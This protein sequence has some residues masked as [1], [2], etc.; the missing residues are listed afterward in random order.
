MR[1]SCLLLG[2]RVLKRC[3]PVLAVLTVTALF[4]GQTKASSQPYLPDHG[5]NFAIGNKYV[6]ET[7]LV[8]QGPTALFDFQR[9]YNSTSTE[10]G[11]LGYGW[12]CSLT[13]RLKIDGSTIT[14]VL[15]TGRHIA[16]E[17]DGAGGW[18]NQLGETSR[19]VG[20][21]GGY[22]LQKAN[23]SLHTYD[24]QGRL[25][26]VRQRN[27]H[28]QE[29]HYSGM[30]LTAITD[31]FGKSL[32]FAYNADGKLHTLT[33]PTG[34]FT[35]SY[36]DD[37][38]VAVVRPDGTTRHYRYT[39]AND[40]HNLTTIDD[41]A[42]IRITS[43]GYDSQDRVIS[44]SLAG[45][46]HVTI[47]YPSELSRTVT[48]DGGNLTTYQLEI[49]NGVARVASSSG[50]GCSSCGSSGADSSY[51]Y[52]GR[53]QVASVTN[54]RGYTTTY[55]YDGNG[56]K[57]VVSEAVGTP[58]QRLTTTTYDQTTNLPTT[59]TR[60]SVGNP[61]QQYRISMT[62]D[63]DGNLLTRSESG[64]DGLSPSTRTT[65][66][67]YTSYGR[68]ETIDGP[69]TDV[70]DVTTFGYYPNTE[71]SGL[72]RGHL[73][74]VTNA[75]GQTVTY[76]DYNALGKPESIRDANQVSTTL[77]YDAFGRVTSRTIG[78]RTT[79]YHYD[80]AGRLDLVSLPGGRALEYHYTPDG[81]L[82]R[83][84]D[85]GGNYLK[86]EY[87]PVSGNIA[88]RTIR[89]ADH[90]LTAEISY[91]YDEF[92][93]LQKE[94]HPD[95][96]GS[97][98]ERSYD[99]AGNLVSL[100]NELGRETTSVYDGLDRLTALI[101]PGAVTTGFAYDVHDNEREVVDDNGITTVFSYN[102]FGRKVEEQSPDRGTILFS[103]DEADNL[104]ARTDGNQVTTVYD[105]DALNRLV[106]KSYPHPQNNVTYHYDQGVNGIGKLT[107]MTDGTGTSS[108]TYNHHGE[109]T[110][111]IRTTQGYSAVVGYG[112]ND[113][114][115]LTSLTY[116]G[117]R[118]VSYIR[119]NDGAI[120]SVVA[121]DRGDSVTIAEAID[122]T[123]FGPLTSMELGNSLHVSRAYDLH[124]RLSSAAAGAVMQRNYSYLVT[125]EIETITDTISPVSSQ[126]FAYNDLGMLVAASGGYGE[127]SYTLDGMG[128]RL[129]KTSDSGAETYS[130]R[131]GSNQLEQ[132]GGIDPVPLSYDDAG[133]TLTKGNLNF[134]WDDENRLVAV[135][136]GALQLGS[137]G[138]DG[139]NLRTVKSTASG[140]ELFIYD[141]AGNV[142]AKLSSSGA[143]R[144]EYIYLNGERLAVFDHSP[145]EAD[146][147]QVIAALQ[148]VSGKP[149][150][151]A[152]DVTGNTIIGLEDAIQPLAE[153]V[154][155]S[156]VQLYYYLTDHLGTVQHVVDEN[157][158]IVWAGEYLPFGEV[159][160]T[161]STKHNDFRFPG[162][163]FD[164]ETGLHYN[165][166]RY[167]DPETGRY[168]SADP[169][170][171]TG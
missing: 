41:E 23:R 102:D 83:I 54:G 149:N 152:V 85:S 122:H 53:Q 133:N 121:T 51:T 27:G 163:S 25:L 161:A 6:V 35:Y 101:R 15:S 141:I 21:S 118:V 66:F 123:P 18:V 78:A 63:T 109:L 16:Y 75:L 31:T 157:G 43:V 116:P 88:K 71:A 52:T 57:E 12:S 159:V 142:L 9:T 138:F 95:G 7:Y 79:V 156:D 166:H 11:I 129:T 76:G 164:V 100:I 82:D 114:G 28:T 139:N 92:G 146:L 132:I 37:N 69:R 8:I 67:T 111:E 19:I 168:I 89:A 50:P 144:E 39:D 58:E 90:T 80:A 72:N 130:Y 3:V 29:F 81:L 110:E 104:I 131:A 124:Y 167:Y 45:H 33:G 55:S 169:I 74:T 140:T 17:S 154:A 97:F 170:G 137:Y 56:N 87:D 49:I 30:Q 38:L 107:G 155:N 94:I 1:K 4:P 64:Y 48:D 136:D 153:S 125:G 126:T 120:T 135:T 96:D 60:D 151:L 2:F 91:Q 127:L 13:D 98:T 84:V 171:L 22:E 93:R 46:R 59:I 143:I 105:Y 77:T 158:Q 14:R 5:V 40:P 34:S 73:Q 42:G 61:G 112:Y 148:I 47:G 44:S 86:Y 36:L 162:Q 160:I 128:N 103:Y 106:A 70:V 62:Y 10:N 117:G 119:D 113:H 32:G 115:E 99:E 134:T 26:Q 108:Y 145:G 20:I 150:S 147:Q 24:Q 65:T 165:W 68:V